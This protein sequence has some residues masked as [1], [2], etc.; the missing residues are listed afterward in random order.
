[1]SPY[2][3]TATM[4][5]SHSLEGGKRDSGFSEQPGAETLRF[6]GA[7]VSGEPAPAG[8]DTSGTT[9]LPKERPRQNG[10]ESQDDGF[11][12]G[13]IPRPKSSGVAGPTGTG[14]EGLTSAVVA[15][16]PQSTMSA[17]TVASGSNP[18]DGAGW[19][20]EGAEVGRRKPR[21]KSKSKG[22]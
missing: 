22:Q 15:R 19:A 7:H 17:A 20:K 8:R 10:L 4:M 18:G 9:W 2:P 12:R 5:S 16:R 1:M 14:I 11:E 3:L 21:H 6:L 13:S